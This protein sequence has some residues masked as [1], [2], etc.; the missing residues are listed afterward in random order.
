MLW[1]DSEQINLFRVEDNVD[2]GTRILKDY[3]SRHGLWTGL[4]RYLGTSEPTDETH[5][6]VKRIQGLY[7]DR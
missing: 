6:Y 2:F 5:A 7:A 1:V 4:T 3:I